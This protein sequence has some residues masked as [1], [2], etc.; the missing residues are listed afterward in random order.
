M[1]VHRLRLRPSCARSEGAASALHFFWSGLFTGVN[2]V[3]GGGNPGGAPHSVLT[4]GPGG[5]GVFFRV[6]TEGIGAGAL[7]GVATGL[8]PHFPKGSKT[9][10][11]LCDWMFLIYLISST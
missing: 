11:S 1:S 6:T 10:H 9:L 4:T 8:T 7:E 2:D 3:H 5:V